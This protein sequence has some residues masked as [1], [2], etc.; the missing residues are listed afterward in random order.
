MA[1]FKATNIPKMLF[2]GLNLDQFTQEEEV[3]PHPDKQSEKL[4]EHSKEQDNLHQAIPA[5][6]LLT[7][8]VMGTSTAVIGLDLDNKILILNKVA[9][10]LL[11]V[12]GEEVTG[13][14]IEEI[15]KLYEDKKE[16]PSNIYAHLKDGK[17]DGIVYQG[18]SL[19]LIT[20]TKLEGEKELFVSLISRQVEMGKNSTLGCVLTLRNI[21]GDV[22]LEDMKMGFV[23]LAAHELRTPITSI[24]GYLAVFNEEYGKKLDNDQKQ[25]LEHIGDST[26]R[27]AQLVENLLSVS[28][29]ERGMMFNSLEEIDLVS[30]VKGVINQI[31]PQSAAKN[32]G[33]ELI[34]PKTIIPKINVD[35]L[36][37]GEVVGNLLKNAIEYNH[38]GGSVSVTIEQ[39]G[40]ELVTHIQD[41]GVGIDKKF[42]PYLFTKF[43][44]I[45]D[46]LTQSNQ[47]GGLGLYISKA[48][49]EMHRG[50]VWVDSNP[51]KGSTFSFSLPL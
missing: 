37:I 8:V 1:L 28:K 49:I 41:T 17:F 31:R 30:L 14:F 27:L 13:K 23:S 42:L 22:R 44:R 12:K 4:V 3:N 35:K 21:T 11:G 36:R 32:I 47:G 18:N 6:D 7:G 16:I 51:K 33:I 38:P 20:K 2:K 48:I 26:E 5:E 15:I 39:K 40:G 46:G 45:T 50:K 34:T 25:L 9:E 24:K 29:V 19:K 43:Y 10:Q